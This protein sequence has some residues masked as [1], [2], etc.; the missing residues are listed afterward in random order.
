MARPFEIKQGSTSPAL[1]YYLE[2]AA[3][4]DLTGATVTFSLQVQDGAVVISEA[5]VTVVDETGTPSVRY[6]WVAG[7]TDTAG[8]YYAEFNVHYQN[9]LEE[10]FPTRGY[11]PV[12]IYDAV[13]P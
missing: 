1:L 13:V 4:I 12:V 8:F 2:P 7:D 10:K 9:G 5:A 11:L 3:D 6:D